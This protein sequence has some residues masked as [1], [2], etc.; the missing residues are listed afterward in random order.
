MP[1]ETKSQAK[2]RAKKLGF[3]Q[4]SVIKGEKS[5][6]IAPRGVESKA[7]KKAYAGCRSKGGAKEKC[8]KI[9]HYVNKKSKGK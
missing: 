9:S 3:K 6:F 4:S 2:S 7:G 5:Y 1:Y 8:A